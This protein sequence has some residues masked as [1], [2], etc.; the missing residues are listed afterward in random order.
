MKKFCAIILAVMM[1]TMLAVNCFADTQIYSG[2]GKVSVALDEEKKIE[3]TGAFKGPFYV[4]FGDQ[5]QVVWS[6]LETGTKDFSFNVNPIASIVEKHDNVQFINFPGQ[7]SFIETAIVQLAIPVNDSVNPNLY[8]IDNNGN[9]V[10]V[11][12]AKVVGTSNKK[13]EFR[14]NQLASTYIISPVDLKYAEGEPVQEITYQDPDTIQEEPA[15]QTDIMKTEEKAPQTGIEDTPYY[16]MIG[17][18][19]AGLA[20]VAASK[21]KKV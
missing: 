14:T 13:F 19:L 3:F 21:K 8:M 6:G 7:P 18:G 12:G 10:Q 20:F 17:A 4:T 2:S 9:I 5:G 16:L 11:N 1:T 15:E